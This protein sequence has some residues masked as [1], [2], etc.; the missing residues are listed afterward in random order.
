M[1]DTNSTQVYE[2]VDENM[3]K[4]EN[5]L[6]VD[7]HFS[8]EVTADEAIAMVDKMVSML[9]DSTDAVA[10]EFTAHRPSIY[11]KYSTEE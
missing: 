8:T 4:A 9:D 2:F 1:S 7:F 10:K 5:I 11:C 3:K 6:T